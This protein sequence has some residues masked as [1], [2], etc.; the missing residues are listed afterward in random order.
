MKDPTHNLML[1]VVGKLANL[2]YNGTHYPVKTHNDTGV[3][4]VV[5]RDVIVNDDGSDTW[6]GTDCIVTVDV[7]TAAMDWTPANS[8][9]SQV[10]ELLINDPPEVT[11]FRLVCLPILESINHMDELSGTQSI[12]RSIVRIIF[13]LQENG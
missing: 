6:F 11:D 7:I 4:V 12:K 13:K 2:E 10:T 8:L 1:A 3:N 9:T 5:V